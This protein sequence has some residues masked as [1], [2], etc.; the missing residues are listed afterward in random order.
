MSYHILFNHVF[1]TT[2][3]E[4]V[5]GLVYNKITGKITLD[6]EEKFCLNKIHVTF[7]KVRKCY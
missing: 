7:F 6:F 4:K 1:I 3:I 2:I 5:S